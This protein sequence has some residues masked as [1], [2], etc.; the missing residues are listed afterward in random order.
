MTTCPKATWLMLNPV[1]QPTL[2]KN[3]LDN[4]L[5]LNKYPAGNT[6]LVIINGSIQKTKQNQ[7]KPH[8][9]SFWHVWTNNP[10]NHSRPRIPETGSIQRSHSWRS[11]A[12]FQ[13][14]SGLQDNFVQVTPKFLSTALMKTTKHKHL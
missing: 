13:S 2:K 12:S 3:M 5:T 10:C 7:P 6:S 11:A 8:T 1:H 4:H 14:M 9:L